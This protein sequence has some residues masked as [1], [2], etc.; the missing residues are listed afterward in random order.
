[1]R[2]RIT[3]AF[4]AV[5]ASAL[6]LAG[7]FSLLLV[8]HAVSLNAQ[9]TVLNDAQAVQNAL[10]NPAIATAVASTPGFALMKSIAGLDAEPVL[11]GA[12][13]RLIPTPSPGSIESFLDG[14]KLLKG[15][16]SAGVHNHVVFAAVPT[17]SPPTGG[18]AAILFSEKEDFRPDSL[19][20]F[21]LAT[22]VALMGA[23]LVA[24][25]VSSRIAAR[26]SVVADASDQIASGDLSTRVPVL[27]EVYPELAQLETAIN[28][29][30]DSLEQSRE[31]EK[32]FLLAIS[33]DLRTPL[34]SI[35]GYA[36][37]IADDA[38]TDLPAA[39]GVVITEARRLDRLIGDLLDLA[40]LRAHQFSFSTIPFDLVAVVTSSVEAFRLQFSQL[41]IGLRLE[42]DAPRWPTLGDPDRV[43]QVLANLIENAMKYAEHEVVIGMVVSDEA[44]TLSV[45]D[46]GPGIDA[47]DLPFVFDRLYSSSRHVARTAGTGL[48]L[49]IV[50]ELCAAMNAEVTV[51]SP[52]PPTS[53]SRGS[54]FNVVIHQRPREALQD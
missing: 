6:F 43:G 4:V 23:G 3:F 54:R 13:G 49:A 41:D 36:E 29:M 9:H 44:V 22:A 31:G 17:Y 48:G 50:T 11:V 2:N 39:A 30:A 37:A 12:N 45:A 38:V 7:V 35:R 16:S 46:D 47:E 51:T 15:L 21:L 19:W 34:T 1:V 27:G 8:R 18:T 20:Y 53:A 33:H 52:T 40:R 24:S 14:K 25:I 10:K 5:L 28:T 42:I 26:V 32:S